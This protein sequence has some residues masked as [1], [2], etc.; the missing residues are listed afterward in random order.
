MFKSLCIAFAMYS[1]IPVP[2]FEWKE[3][4]MKY[5]FVFFPFIGI[6]IGGLQLLLYYLCRHMLNVSEILY[7]G[8][9]TLVPILITGGIHMDGYADTIDAL[10][11]YQTSR[12]R[13]EILKDPHAGAFAIIWTCIYF[14]LNFCAWSMVDKREIIIAVAVG[15]ILSRT[16]SGMAAVTFKSAKSDGTLAAFKNASDRNT[17]RL[18]LI[19]IFV[20]CGAIQIA[21]S[22]LRG[23]VIVLAQILFMAYYHNMAM[24]KFGGIT[25][26]LEGWFLQCTELL[27]LYMAIVV[28]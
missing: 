28:R 19:A 14:M 17:V 10:S 13:L 22:P 18:V 23:A 15:Y 5:S 25:G 24:K 2:G 4:N 12:R 27:I 26:D 16:L 9:A 20:I 21:E 8:L 7:C 1:K 6:I 11:S 3:E